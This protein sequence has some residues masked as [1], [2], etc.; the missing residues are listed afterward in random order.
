M[1]LRDKGAMITGAGDGIGRAIAGARPDAVVSP[2]CRAV[3][4]GRDQRP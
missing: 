2:S 4:R 3:V 1:R